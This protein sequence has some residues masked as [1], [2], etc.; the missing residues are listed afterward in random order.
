MGIEGELM[1]GVEFE[2]NVIRLGITKSTNFIG[3]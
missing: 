3:G 1:G 2:E